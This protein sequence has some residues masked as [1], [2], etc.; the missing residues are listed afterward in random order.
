MFT[1][2]FV[3]SSNL[4]FI[5]LTREKMGGGIAKKEPNLSPLP[6]QMLRS[7]QSPRSQT[8]QYGCS[9]EAAMEIMELSW[10]DLTLIRVIYCRLLTA[11]FS[12]FE[13][14]QIWRPHNLFGQPL[15]MF[16]HTQANEAFSYVW[17]V[18]KFAGSILF[19]R[20]CQVYTLIRAFFSLGWTVPAISV[21]PHILDAPVP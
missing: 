7:C 8:W 14:L 6:V 5:C 18:F 19:T 9:E 4:F 2:F 13:L 1:L 16:N 15:P 10:G 11:V 21:I 3:S 17:M 12:S 20:S